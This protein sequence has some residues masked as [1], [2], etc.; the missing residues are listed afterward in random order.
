[1]LF[2]SPQSTRR[3]ERASEKTFRELPATSRE[4]SAYSGWVPGIRIAYRQQRGYNFTYLNTKYTV[5][6]TS[7]S[8][9][10]LHLNL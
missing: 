1:M 2:R 10:F 4:N 8:D 3:S 5:I 9:L 6:I 7:Q